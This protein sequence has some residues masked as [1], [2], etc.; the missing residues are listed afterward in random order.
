MPSRD[1]AAARLGRKRTAMTVGRLVCSARAVMRYLARECRPSMPRVS[2]TRTLENALRRSGFCLVAGT[3]EAGRGCLAGPVTAGVVILNPDRHIPG[4]ADSKAVPPDERSDLY[5]EI[6]RA[7]TAWAVA[8]SDPRTIDRMN[9]HQASLDAMRRAVLA[10]TPLPDMVI[11]DAFHIPG[12][13]MAQRGVKH[14]DRRCAAIAAASIVAKV[15][16]DR[17]MVALHQRDPRFGFDRHK[18]YATADHLAA[19]A[20][21]GY[22]DAHRRSFRPSTLF[23]TMA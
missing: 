1:R 5:D 23:D 6:V 18:G 10:L 8:S 2:A 3:D 11:V 19:V 4:L 17:E 13:P 12:L 22:S 21:F 7:A 20:Q 9:I 15:T 14:G 16:R